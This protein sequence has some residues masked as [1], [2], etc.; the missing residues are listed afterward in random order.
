MNK[1]ELKGKEGVERIISTSTTSGGDKLLLLFF[2]FDSTQQQQHPPP[3]SIVEVI[4]EFIDWNL[5][6]V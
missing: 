6:W 4:K 5:L 2:A 1:L 3:M